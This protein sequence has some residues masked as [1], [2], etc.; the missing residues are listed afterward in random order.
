MPD[1]R[2]AA[3]GDPPSRDIGP[4]A[5][6]GEVGR[7]L[8]PMAVGS[9]SLAAAAWTV[10]YVVAVRAVV[11]GRGGGSVPGVGGR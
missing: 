2:M 1:P 3:A 9:V 5:L 7:L 11:A 6:L 10:I 4:G 8:W